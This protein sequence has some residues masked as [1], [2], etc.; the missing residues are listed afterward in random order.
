MSAAV[1][2]FGSDGGLLTGV[3]VVNEECMVTFGGLDPFKVKAAATA[4][5]SSGI[6]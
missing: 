6:R 2:R 5:R 3:A 4:P 1:G